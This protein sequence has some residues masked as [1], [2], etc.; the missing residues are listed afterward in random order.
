M[1]VDDSLERQASDMVTN[2]IDAVIELP[3]IAMEVVAAVSSYSDLS[4]AMEISSADYV[5]TVVHSDIAVRM[6][7]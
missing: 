5:H 3:V 7:S 1:N 2:D 4:L 6:N